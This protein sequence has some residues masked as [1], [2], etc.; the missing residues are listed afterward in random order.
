M[1]GRD[2]G[3][4]ESSGRPSGPWDPGLQI[5]RTTLAWSRTALAFVVGAAVFIRLLVRAD[6]VLATVCAALTLPL[7]VIITRLAWRR[8]RQDERSLRSGA[9]LSDGAL[10]ASL[11]V[12]TVLVGGIGL[13][14]V[15]VN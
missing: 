1:P 3:D 8:H 13:T 6:I 14:Y 4:R 9:P 12:L 11:A 10:P 5:E 15:L 7:V 2:S